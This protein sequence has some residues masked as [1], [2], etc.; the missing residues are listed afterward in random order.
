MHLAKLK[1]GLRRFPQY[2]DSNGSPIIATF[3]TRSKDQ[4]PS[5]SGTALRTCIATSQP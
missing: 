3:L 2:L 1:S 4:T 5:T